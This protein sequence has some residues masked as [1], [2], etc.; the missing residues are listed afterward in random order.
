MAA[1]G[2]AEALGPA[3]WPRFMRGLREAGRLHVWDPP[4][5][6]AGHPHKLRAL[7]P[8]PSLLKEFELR[9]QNDLTAGTSGPSCFQCPFAAKVCVWVGVAPIQPARVMLGDCY[10]RTR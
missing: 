3:S 4:L 9:A 10:D 5:L 1:P 7:L 6:V 8:H 2:P